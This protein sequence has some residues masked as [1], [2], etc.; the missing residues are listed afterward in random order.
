MNSK[1]FMDGWR[2]NIGLICPPDTSI[3]VE[4]L[5]SICPDGLAVHQ[6][7]LPL[8]DKEEMMTEQQRI[9]A[10]IG[11]LENA[12]RT[13]DLVGVD[14]IGQFGAPFLFTKK[15]EFGTYLEKTL[16][17]IS[18]TPVI[19]MALA[20]V[21]AIKHLGVRRINAVTYYS[22]NFNAHYKRYLEESGLVV[23]SITGLPETSS[24]KPP[25]PKYAEISEGR[26]FRFAK[27]V[28]LKKQDADCLLLSGGGCRTFNIIE[29]LEEDLGI[30]VVSSNSAFFWKILSEL[31][32]GH[33]IV[34]HGKLLSQLFRNV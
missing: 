3:G 4:E 17:N 7:F 13:L 25:S 21:E 31:R 33:K 1:L 32:I 10:M 22:D 34:G 19:L 5:K 15:I 2:G 20:T 8:N 26:I 30:P 28:F 29:P 14:V 27:S 16:S 18:K 9:D 11:G 12:V 6:T 23:S 24:V